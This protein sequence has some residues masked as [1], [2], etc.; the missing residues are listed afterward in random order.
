LC[1]LRFTATQYAL[2]SALASIVGRFLTGTSVGA[3]I[4]AIGY[5]NFYLLTTAVALPG[6]IL[7]WVM[8]R[9]GLADLSIGSAGKDDE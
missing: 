6:V 4:N 1:N 2:L 7:F 9:S 8:I 3:L 5:V